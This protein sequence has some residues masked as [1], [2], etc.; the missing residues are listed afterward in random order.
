[1]KNRTAM[2]SPKKIL[3]VDDDAV[4]VQ[5][6]SLLLQAKGYQVLTAEDGASTI[7]R[8]RREKPD[9]IL[10]D[11]N[12]PP[13]VSHG[14]AVN[15][16]GFRIMEWLRRMEEAKG[17]PIIVV[18]V[19]D[20]AKDQDRCRAPEVAGFFRKPVDNAELLHTIRKALEG[21]IRT[22]PPA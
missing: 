6:L 1:M 4:F 3:I 19:A 22:E 16:N 11:L 10:L 5:A 15:W 8:V 17:V 13:D 7:S 2:M 12:F 18:T 14:G 9:L 20:S 21:K